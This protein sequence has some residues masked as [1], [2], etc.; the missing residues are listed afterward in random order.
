MTRPDSIMLEIKDLK[1]SIDNKQILNG[2]SL[3]IGPG[4]VRIAMIWDSVNRD[5]RM[6]HLLGHSLP[7]SSTQSWL[8]IW[9]I[10]HIAQ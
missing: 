4:E 2:L 3:S 5:F 1:A 6:S 8:S 10:R 9:G 7:E